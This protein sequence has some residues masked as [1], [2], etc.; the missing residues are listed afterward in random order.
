M[1]CTITLADTAAELC[2]SKPGLKTRMWWA[3]V[4]DITSIGAATDHVVSTITPVSTKGFY[5]LYITRKDNDQASTPNENGGYT[6]EIKGFISKQEAAKSKVFTQANGA[7]AFIFITE[8]QNGLKHIIGSVDHPV[9][10]TFKP[11]TTPKNGYEL[12][13][14]WDEHSDIPFIFS[15]TVPL[16][17]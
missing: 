4:S 17:S 8:D 3:K 6:T 13:A 5:L 2:A 1:A 11:T 9:M 12:Q 15:G 14:K 16:P 7:E 10:V